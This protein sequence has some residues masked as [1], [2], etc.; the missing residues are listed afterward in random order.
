VSWVEFWNGKTTIY[1]NA[2][3]EMAHYRRIADEIAAL[4]LER[5]ARVLD[6]G[7]GAAL[8]AERVADACGHLYLCDSAA[9]TRSALAARLGGRNDITILAPE[10]LTSVPDGSLDL[11]VVNSVIQ[12]LTPDDLRRG[13]T[14][15]REKLSGQG[16]LLIADVIP[17]GI[18][19]LSDAAALLK[20]AAKDGFFFA[21][22]AGLVKTFFS[23]YRQLRARLGLQMF[24]DAEI[25]A[26]LE[27]NGLKA[28]RHFPNLGHNSSRM[29][30]M[31]TRARLPRQTASRAEVAD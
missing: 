31:A 29:A 6:F 19:P 16:R 17:P 21:A 27:E 26:L 15:W 12:Y 30:F 24:H 23:D 8:A 14:L 5:N 4:V 11:I 2:R 25:V 10:D 22:C 18:G 13:L 7:C 28:R 1:A 3:H 20:F 9:T